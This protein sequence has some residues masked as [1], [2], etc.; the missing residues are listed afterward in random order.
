M[1][2]DFKQKTTILSV[3]MSPVVE[4]ARTSLHIY[5]LLHPGYTLSTATSAHHRAPPCVHS[6]RLHTL[7]AFIMLCAFFY[8]GVLIC[9]LQFS[10]CARFSTMAS[11]SAASIFLC[12]HDFLRWRLHLPPTSYYERTFFYDG[13]FWEQ[14]NLPRT[15]RWPSQYSDLWPGLKVTVGVRDSLSQP[16]LLSSAME[17]ATP[18]ALFVDSSGV[19]DIS[20]SWSS[21]WWWRCL[22]WKG[23]SENLRCVCLRPPRRLDMCG[24]SFLIVFVLY[25]CNCVYN[26]FSSAWNK[27]EKTIRIELEVRGPEELKKIKKF[28]KN[29]D[30]PDWTH[31]PLSHPFYWKH[32][33]KNTKKLR[34]R[35]N[36]FR[37]FLDFLNFANLTRPLNL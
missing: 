1:S 33:Q 24:L 12:A 2:Y 19:L 3:Q 32:V 7:G 10:M 6:H 34:L 23:C 25:I 14:D 28:E 9:R 26:R 16:T 13:A 36:N 15:R 35:P 18:S 21:W 30:W 5:C 17:I 29:S 20:W 37:V 22:W 8:D 4:R 27:S 11:S 31:P